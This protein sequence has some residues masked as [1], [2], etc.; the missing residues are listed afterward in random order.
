MG[1]LGAS[2]WGPALIS[3]GGNVAGPLIAGR[4]ADPS[5]AMTSP[6]PTPGQNR[7]P[8]GLSVNQQPQGPDQTMQ[9]LFALMQQ[10]AKMNVGMSNPASPM[11][12]AIQGI[13]AGPPAQSMNQ[14]PQIPMGANKYGG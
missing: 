5:G 9:I 1:D 13:Q 8:Q 14:M 12:Q 10:L 2:V 4:G 7:I 11:Q 6:A 3:A